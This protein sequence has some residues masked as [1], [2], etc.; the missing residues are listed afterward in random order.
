MHSKFT[1]DINSTPS[2]AHTHQGAQK[3]RGKQGQFC[4]EAYILA[5]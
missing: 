1:F 3:E 4:H 5:G 2:T